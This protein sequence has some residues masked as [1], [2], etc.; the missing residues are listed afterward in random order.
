MSLLMP[1][2][3]VIL[4][5]YNHSQFLKKRIDSILNQ[6]FQDFELIILDDCSTDSSKEIIEAYSSNLKVTNVVYNLTN[7]GSTFRQWKKG[8]QLAKG[9]YIWFAESDDY[10]HADF[11][12]NLVS[13]LEKHSN[14]GLIFCNSHII[15][16]EDTIIDNTNDWTQQYAATQKEDKITYLNGYDFCRDHLF[17]LCRIPNASAV[18]FKREIVVDNLYWIDENLKNSGDWKLW[19]NIALHADLIWMN[20][21]LN[22]FR[23]HANNVTN[24]QQY[25]KPEALSIL[26]EIINNKSL[27]KQYRLFESC[28]IW[29]FN[30]LSWKR[31][32]RYTKENFILYFN[33]NLSISSV[34]SLIYYLTKQSYFFTRNLFTKK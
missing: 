28:C 10:A 2:V 26:K 15:N 33:N 1:T 5:N 12:E 30:T 25:L 31:D 21:D 6:S 23:K 7:S 16:A 17:L 11:L 9:K 13:I 32:A 20:K 22:Y 4:P 19:L 18:V 8:I 3:S 29:S 27:K 34:I 24:S 14:A